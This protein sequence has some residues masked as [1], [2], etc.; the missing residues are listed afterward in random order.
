MVPVYCAVSVISVTGV[1]PVV[2]AV[3]PEI[4]AI[5]TAVSVSVSFSVALAVVLKYVQAIQSI[6]RM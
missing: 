6:K 2:G 3:T 4:A 5:L 1:S